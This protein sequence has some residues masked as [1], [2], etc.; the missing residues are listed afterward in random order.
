V[1]TA[2]P[3][4]LPRTVEP[5]RYEITLTPDIEAATFAGDERIRV[6]V[7]EATD[8]I[9]LNA[10]ELQIVSANLI[11]DDGTTIEGHIPVDEDSEVLTLALSQPA[12]AGAWMLHI[13]FSGELN[14]KLRGFYR[15]TFTD[16][17]G[18][19]RVIA[20]TQFEATDARRAFPCWDEP[21]FKA[22]FAVTLIVDDHLAAFSNA[23]VAEEA[24]LD[25]GKRQVEFADTM[26]MS[27]YLVAFVV[28]PLVVTEVVDVDGVPLRIACV[29]GRERLT[30]FAI[31]TSRFPTLPLAQ[32][33]IWVASHIAKPRCSWTQNEPVGWKWSASQTS[34][35]TKRPTCGSEIS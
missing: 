12:D 23:A 13:A 34:S 6:T 5:E 28:G 24:V 8:T 17:D 19:E 11:G 18:V 22:V 1:A 3:Y 20:T 21:D 35:H 31:E 7:H 29:P 15:S 25:N 9:S 10:A 30:G 33:R 32:W 14:D 16:D 27:T 4:R 26:K 2:N